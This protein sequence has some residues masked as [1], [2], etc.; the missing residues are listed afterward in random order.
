MGY[1]LLNRLKMAETENFGMHASHTVTQQVPC[2]ASIIALTCH[3][4][5]YQ[6]KHKILLSKQM[7]A[8]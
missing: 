8:K 3:V 2:I 1:D 6:S 4:I 5:E 7:C